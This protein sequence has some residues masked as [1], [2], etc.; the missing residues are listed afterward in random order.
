MR[1]LG[2]FPVSQATFEFSVVPHFWL[3]YDW[4]ECPLVQTFQV[5]EVF[6]CY[7]YSS[8]FGRQTWG[9]FFWKADRK[10]LHLL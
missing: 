8:W 2:A 3:R 5:M 4:F 9:V 10:K 6:F 7:G 1:G